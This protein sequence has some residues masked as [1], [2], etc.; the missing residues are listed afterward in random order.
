ML[1]Q[2]NNVSQRT[3]TPN[4]GAKRTQNNSSQPA[5]KWSKGQVAGGAITVVSLLAGNLVS[6][7]WGQKAGIKIGYQETA[8]NA[9]KIISEMQK[10]SVDLQKI[11]FEQKGGDSTPEIVYRDKEGN[12][13]V[14]GLKDNS[15]HK[16]LIDTSY[17]KNPDT[18][19]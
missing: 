18:D 16:E 3:Y 14:M 2:V 15:K 13:I 4:V 10:D 7:Y 1:N 11:R 19:R 6:N 8:N 17:V 12:D 9:I 5:F